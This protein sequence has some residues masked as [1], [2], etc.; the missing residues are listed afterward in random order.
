MGL[1]I[2]TDIP[3]GLLGVGYPANE[4]GV[5]SGRINPYPN[6][7]VQMV[8]EGH[9]KTVAYSMWLNDLREYPTSTLLSGL[10]ALETPRLTRER[11]EQTRAR[12]ASSSAASTRP[13]TRAR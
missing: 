12:G 9:I 4:A 7:P 6:L 2:D 13:S 5:S 11:N 8:A 1:G 3:F 10:A